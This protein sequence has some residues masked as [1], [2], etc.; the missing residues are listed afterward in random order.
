MASPAAA[1]AAMTIMRNL[2]MNL[3]PH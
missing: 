1:I 2:L 3:P